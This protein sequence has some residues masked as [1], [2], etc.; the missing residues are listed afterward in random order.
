MNRKILNLVVLFSLIISFL[1]YAKVNRQ[2]LDEK[3]RK[4]ISY[5][6]D[7]DYAEAIAIFKEIQAEDPT[8]RTSQIRRY[9]RV[10]EG[11]LGRMGVK[12]KFVVGEPTVKEVKIKKEGEFQVLARESQ[13]VLLDTY[14]F[15]SDARGEVVITDI[16]TAFDNFKTFVKNLSGLEFVKKVDINYCEVNQDRNVIE[17]ALLVSVK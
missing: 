8:Y 5:Y 13:K 14:Q 1:T 11:R 3:Y 4:A 15:F 12:K 7:K 9:I 17:F 2:E 6:Y 16:K 10:A